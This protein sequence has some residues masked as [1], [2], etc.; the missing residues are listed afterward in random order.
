MAFYADALLDK[1]NFAEIEDTPRLVE[2]AQK[3]WKDSPA[4]TT[5]VRRG[6]EWYKLNRRKKM[7]CGEA[8]VDGV[9]EDEIDDGEEKRAMFV[10]VRLWP[11][12][13]YKDGEED[14]D[15]ECSDGDYTNG[16]YADEE[17]SEEAA[18]TLEPISSRTVLEDGGAHQ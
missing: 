14:G 7:L 11:E 6:L 4:L 3:W 1:F 13:A 18:V 9:V 8:G 2:F 10:R 16:D 17:Y 5:V 15:G 12:M